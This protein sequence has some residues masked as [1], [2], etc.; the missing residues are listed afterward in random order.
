MQK[1][2]R[3]TKHS[4]GNYTGITLKMLR[5]IHVTTHTTF[6]GQRSRSSNYCL[7]LDTPPRNNRQ[8]L[9]V[10]KSAHLSFGSWTRPR[11]FVILLTS[12]AGTFKRLTTL[13]AVLITPGYSRSESKEATL[14]A[15]IKGFEAP[16]PQQSFFAQSQLPVHTPTIAFRHLPPNSARFSYATEGAL[17]ISAQLS[18]DAV[19]ALRKVRVLI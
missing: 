6:I 10:H 3:P 11:G 9:K 18:A 16:V 12:I 5:H 7:N 14:P 4:V 19:S 13:P 17:F 2:P 8:F 1:C 15:S